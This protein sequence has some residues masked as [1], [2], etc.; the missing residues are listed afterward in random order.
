MLAR[1]C[2]VLAGALVAVPGVAQGDIQ[3]PRIVTY[4]RVATLELKA[5]VFKPSIPAAGSRAAIVIFHGGGWSAGEPAWVYSSARRFAKRGM[6]AVAIQY[7]LS[8]QKSVTPLDAMEDARD[9]IRWVRSQATSLGVDPRRVAAYG[10][11]AG[12]QLAAAA[13]MIGRTEAGKSDLSAVPDALVLY[14]P[15]VAVA[16]SGWM[17]RLLLGRA[18]PED[19]SPDQFVC[20]G[21]PPTLI[22]Q[23]EED[24][25]TPYEGA[26]RF[27]RS[28]KELGNSCEMRHYAGLGHLLTRKLDEQESEFDP[29]P[30]ARA[31]ASR[32]EERFLAQRGFIEVSLPPAL[33]G[34]EAVVRAL[35]EAIDT[36]DLEAILKR[37]AGDTVWLEVQGEQTRPEFKGRDALCKS[38]KD[39]FKSVPSGRLELHM[40]S[41]NGAFVSVRERVTWKDPQG[42]PRSRNAFAL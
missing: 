27:S 37:V 35:A 17:R 6:V 15:A 20:A 14:S 39:R 31:D 3:V 26:Y 25:L 2:L 19:A 1:S 21:I 41:T 8:D 7:R 40:L 23:G 32:A 33:E 36:Q 29:D 34:P 10:V 28:L 18:K 13:A 4:K 38:L 42:E 16:Q 5:H 11:S 22:I 24:A 9:A 12:G 30:E